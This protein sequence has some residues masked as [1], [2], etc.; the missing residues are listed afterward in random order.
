[1]STLFKGDKFSC[2]SLPSRLHVPGYPVFQLDE[3]LD[4]NKNII[5]LVNSNDT[6]DDISV[7]DYVCCWG[8]L[9]QNKTAISSQILFTFPTNDYCT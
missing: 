2:S 7:Y 1:M 8:R 3:M 4:I 5:I 6:E 9:Q